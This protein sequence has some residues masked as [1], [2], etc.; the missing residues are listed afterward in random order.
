M[1]ICLLVSAVAAYHE[2]DKAIKLNKTY[3][4]YS[5]NL[6]NELIIFLENLLSSYRTMLLMCVYKLKQNVFKSIIHL[7]W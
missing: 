4:K 7:F 2:S 1:R 5:E 6:L 3:D